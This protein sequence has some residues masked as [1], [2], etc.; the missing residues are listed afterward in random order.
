MSWNLP[1]LDIDVARRLLTFLEDRR[2][3]HQLH[4]CET[5]DHVVRSILEIRLRIP[6]KPS[7]CSG[8]VVQLSA[9]SD[10]PAS[11][12]ASVFYPQVVGISNGESI[13]RRVRS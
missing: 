13:L 11:A 3:L 10:E 5:G 1:T 8:D 7:T 9:R 2:A 4:E 12:A 6:A